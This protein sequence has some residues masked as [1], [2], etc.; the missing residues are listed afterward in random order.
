MKKKYIWEGINCLIYLVNWLEKLQFWLLIFYRFVFDCGLINPLINWPSATPSSV[1]NRLQNY[2]ER[3]AQ[4]TLEILFN[5][6][7][8]R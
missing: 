3:N 1:T 8:I 5:I 4:V 7:G 2:P 6:M